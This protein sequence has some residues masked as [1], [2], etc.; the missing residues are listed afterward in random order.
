MTIE[1]IRYIFRQLNDEKQKMAKDGYAFAF[2][3]FI[4]PMHPN[5]DV[6][7]NFTGGGDANLVSGILVTQ[8]SSIYMYEVNNGVK[9]TPEEFANRVAMS[10]VQD[11]KL[12]TEPKGPSIIVQK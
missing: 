4:P 5:Q 12:R 11:I 1:K 2:G 8:L 7:A 10:L 3:Y 6:E 9:E